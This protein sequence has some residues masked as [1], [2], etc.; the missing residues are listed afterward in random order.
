MA[1]STQRPTGERLGENMPGLHRPIPSPSIL[2]VDD[3]AA[4]TSFLRMG[5]AR[6][7]YEV[8]VAADGPQALAACDGGHVDLV[9]LDLMLP[10]MD[11]VEVC[12]R[13]RGNPDLLVLMLTAADA[14]G[15]RIRGLDGGADDY[16]VKPFDFEELLARIRALLRRRLPDQQL[17]LS[18]G[19]YVLDD[20]AMTVT[21][22][23][24]PVELTR[25]E[26]DLFKLFLRHPRQVLTRHVIVDQVW[27]HTFY[28]DANVVDVYVRYLRNKLDPD[29][30]HIQ[31]VRGLGYRL[32]A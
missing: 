15:Q 16:L 25:R 10:G 13:L 26:Y 18:A 28:G 3:E 31:T 8:T 12:Q 27:G 7:G 30:A 14:V 21:R 20:T 23:G 11:G 29:R 9:V 24:E 4:I 17:L 1:D 5:L 32:M 6:A 19:P 22:D 2:V